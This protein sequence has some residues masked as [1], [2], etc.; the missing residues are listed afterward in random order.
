MVGLPVVLAPAVAGALA[1]R[2]EV[3]IAA[4]GA[5]ALL[6]VA[7]AVYGYLD[8]RVFGWAV[9]E[10][11]LVTRQ[12]VVW[13]KTVVVPLVRIQHVELASGPL[14]RAFGTARL[15][16]FTAGSGG[17]DL[18]IYGLEPERAERLRGHLRT[19]I[20]DVVQ[21]TSTVVHEVS[22]D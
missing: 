19:Q 8:A 12:G 3:G 14:E 9:R 6:A 2:V 16:V 11:D 7:L 1:F 15:Q 4:G 22:R 17:A 21:E 10:H 18:V 20:D 13:R 5:A